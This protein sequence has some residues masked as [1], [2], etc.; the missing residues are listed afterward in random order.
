MNAARAFLNGIGRERPEPSDTAD[1]VWMM[2]VLLANGSPAPRPVVGQARRQRGR[3]V[4][5]NAARGTRDL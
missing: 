3:T 1:D 5:R 2:N 4:P